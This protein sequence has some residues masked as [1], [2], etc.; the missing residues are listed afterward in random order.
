MST[1]PFAADSALPAGDFPFALAERQK[2]AVAAGEFHFAAA[3]LDHGHVHDQTAALIEAG[4][5]LAGVFD[6]RPER[7]EAFRKRFGPVPAYAQFD[8]LLADAT[9]SLVAAAAVPARRA[10]IGLQVMAAGKDYFTDKS[11]FT[12]LAQLE[13]VRAAV[14]AT[15]RRYFVYY[16]ERVHNRPSWYAAELARH[17]AIGRVVQ[18]LIMAPHNLG[19]YR[20]PAWFFD[21]SQYGG[22]LT[23]IGSHQF[24]QFLYISGS[25]G[26]R[27]EHARV[28][29][30][31]NPGTPGLED[32]GEA[33][34][35]LDDGTSAYCRVD[36]FNPAASR[37]WGDGRTFILGT[38][39]YIEVRRNVDA[40]RP[41]GGP[42]IVLVN[43]R[44]E[45]LIR[46][47]GTEALPFFGR[48]IRDCL[49]G[50]ERAMSQAHAFAAAELSMRAQVFA[51][52]HRSDAATTR[53]Q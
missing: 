53:E 2:P 3:W 23:D 15:R 49:D 38:D 32:F 43:N 48:L 45:R 20:R 46:F 51:D 29:N 21:K 7:V 13:R 36:W 37:T 52:T 11:P 12:D 39:G 27:I 1:H 16:A 42:C 5:T 25:A 47:D 28:A 33:S 34:V 40:G 4:A 10:D 6:P 26:G 41:E 24:E 14:V 30:L 22:I 50:T 9:I 19:N 31:A 17:G 35:T 8:D 44:E 18:V